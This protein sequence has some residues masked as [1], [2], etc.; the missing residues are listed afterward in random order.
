MFWLT[1]FF[2]TDS[3]T[4]VPAWVEEGQRYAVDSIMFLVGNKSDL[5]G[6]R[7]TEAS[8][9]EV[10]LPQRTQT[11]SRSFF[12]FF[13]WIYHHTRRVINCV[14]IPMQEYAK[15]EEIAFYMET[16]AKSGQNID[17]LFLAVAK[18]LEGRSVA[19]FFFP[20]FL[21]FDASSPKQSFILTHHWISLAKRERERAYIF[22]FVCLFVL[23]VSERATTQRTTRRTVRRREARARLISANPHRP[24]NKSQASAPYKI[25]Y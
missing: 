1:H 16:S 14:L 15:D 12:F 23:I 9:A 8:K 21:F 25:I 22:F 5:S 17:A 18:K 7:V 13:F 24:R 10:G 19:A 20:F 11:T 2:F 3:Y 4:D 6:E